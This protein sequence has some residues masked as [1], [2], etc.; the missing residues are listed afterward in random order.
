MTKFYEDE[1]GRWVQ[2][3]D[4]AQRQW[5]ERISEASTANHLSRRSLQDL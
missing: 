5:Y 1:V 4:N 3:E 2:L